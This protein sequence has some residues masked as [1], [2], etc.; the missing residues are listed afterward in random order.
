MSW[1][2]K[3]KKWNFKSILKVYFVIHENAFKIIFKMLTQKQIL[4]LNATPTQEISTSSN[5]A[6]L[7]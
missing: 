5:I 3:L 2:Y 7:K 4:K 1:T 6:K